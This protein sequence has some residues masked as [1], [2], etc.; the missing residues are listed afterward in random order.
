LT[1]IE[2]IK[3]SFTLNFLPSYNTLY[4]LLH[5]FHLSKNVKP[6]P[7]SKEGDYYD[8]KEKIFKFISI[9]LVILISF[10]TNI[11]LAHGAT[12][13]PSNSDDTFRE[14]DIIKI[15]TNYIGEEQRSIRYINRDN[16]EDFTIH[17]YGIGTNNY[18]SET[19]AS[20]GSLLY[21]VEQVDDMLTTYD[22]KGNIAAVTTVNSS[23]LINSYGI[24]VETIIDF[25]SQALY[26]W[27]S[28]IKYGK[29][30]TKFTTW[31]ISAIIT[32]FV[33]ALCATYSIGWFA[34]SA[35]GTIAS[36]IAN[37]MIPTVYYTGSRQLGWTYGTRVARIN[38]DVY[39]YSYTSGYIGHYNEIVNVH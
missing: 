15:E 33:A 35:L 13:L 31:T 30:N 2:F 8:K 20:D 18:Y 28:Y 9:S 16:S 3:Q 4:D 1:N 32:T 21:K 11:K 27:D 25:S 14:N 23:T 17:A 24:S 7:N 34:S 12:A 29:G 36:T 19:S 37:A 5:F 22:S 26:T 39:R 38:C 10:S 6:T